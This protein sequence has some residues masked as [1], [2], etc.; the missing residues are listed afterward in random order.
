[1]RQVIESARSKICNCIYTAVYLFVIISIDGYHISNEF[2]L[3]SEI[4]IEE[5]YIGFHTV[6]IS[7]A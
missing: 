4:Y 1:M 7:L 6:Y 3:V 5:V 2:K